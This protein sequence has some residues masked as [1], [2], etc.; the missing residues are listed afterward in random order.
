M[1]GLGDLKYSC[2]RYLSG[3]AYCF[4]VKKDFV[5]QNVALRVQF[6]MLILAC[7]SQETN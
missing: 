3:G 2:H 7:L 1:S 5:K 6:Q 4:F